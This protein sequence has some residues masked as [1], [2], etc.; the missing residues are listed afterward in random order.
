[1]VS[2]LPLVCMQDYASNGPP[3]R[4]HLMR[5]VNASGCLSGIITSCTSTTE[6]VTQLWCLQRSQSGG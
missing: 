5:T 4:H 3:V 2:L 1:M 6:G